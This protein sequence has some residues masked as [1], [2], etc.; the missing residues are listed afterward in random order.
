MLYHPDRNKG[1]EMAAEKF[2]DLSKAYEI[3]G[4]FRLRKLYDKGII[5]TAGREYSEAASHD[6]ADPEDDPQTKFYKARMKRSDAPTPTGR[7]PI[8]DFDEWSR[9]HYGGT[10]ARRQEGKRKFVKNHQQRQMDADSVKKDFMLFGLV[11]MVVGFMVI[12]SNM[13]SYDTVVDKV[14]KRKKDS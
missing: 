12:S 11:F 5:H 13:E 1:S 4:N 6:I 14:E 2:R 9:A 10:F 8:Y 3:L 7:T